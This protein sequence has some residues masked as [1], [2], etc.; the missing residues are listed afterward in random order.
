MMAVGLM[1]EY[2]KFQHVCSDVLKVARWVFRHRDG[3]I[4]SFMSAT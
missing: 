3:I 4:P 2:L 1:V